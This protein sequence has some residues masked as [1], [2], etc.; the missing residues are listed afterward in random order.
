LIKHGGGLLGLAQDVARHASRATSASNAASKGATRDWDAVLRRTV[1]RLS[2]IES[3]SIDESRCALRMPDDAPDPPAHPRGR[4]WVVSPVAALERADAAQAAGM[5][6]LCPGPRSRWV[7]WARWIPLSSC[8][9]CQ[10]FSP[11][12]GPAPSQRMRSWSAQAGSCGSGEF[13]MTIIPFAAR[14][15]TRRRRAAELG[16]V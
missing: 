9:P 15:R 3:T 12:T 8:S 6:L 1:G 7:A 16:T 14:S 13:S 5:A 4:L 10:T 2:A 11:T